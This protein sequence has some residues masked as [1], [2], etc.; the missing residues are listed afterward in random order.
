MEV[1]LSIYHTPALSR[2]ALIS[3]L[4]DLV[5]RVTFLVD[6]EARLIQALLDV[7]LRKSTLYRLVLQHD[8]IFYCD[9]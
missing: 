4:C 1:I 3:H 6:K 8:V 7:R 2:Q 5:Q 9:L